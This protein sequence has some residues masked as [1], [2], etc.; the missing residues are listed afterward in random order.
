MSINKLYGLF[1]LQREVLP[2]NV[3]NILME[4]F[5]ETANECAE[6][7]LIKEALEQ[8]GYELIHE[9]DD[10]IGHIVAIRKTDDISFLF[11]NLDLVP[12]NIK[13][14]V[15]KHTEAMELDYVECEAF[16][17]ELNDAGFTFFY[18]LDA[19]PYDLRPMSELEKTS[20]TYKKENKV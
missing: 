16:L 13:G 18:G 4:F 8:E 12:D 15:N 19:S 9:D 2:K 10:E 6:F 7:E 11:E 14:I 1:V 5:G 3:Q 17:L 20:H